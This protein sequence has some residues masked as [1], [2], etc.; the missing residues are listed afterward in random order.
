M[1]KQNGFS[2]IEVIIAAAIFAIGMI[3]LAGM[4]YTS[5]YSVGAGD[6]RVIATNLVEQSLEAA[7]NKG[8]MQFN[9]NDYSGDYDSLGNLVGA[10]FSSGVKF[11]RAVTLS[12]N[13]V[14]STV[15]W[16]VKGEVK[17]VTSSTFL[18]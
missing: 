11:T 14:T 18:Y 13:I 8:L 3:A 6:R 4:Q 7:R 5:F 12:G 9:L 16:N 1:K 2:L 15:S 10:D 17:N